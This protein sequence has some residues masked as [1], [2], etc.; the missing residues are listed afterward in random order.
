MKIPLKTN[1]ILLI[2]IFSIFSTHSGTDI[3]AGLSLVVGDFA[4]ATH[5]GISVSFTPIT[6]LNQYFGLGG[7]IDYS[8]ITFDTDSDLKTGNHLLDIGV[9]PRSLFL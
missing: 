7:H 9:V 5:P 6:K 8:W 4:K 2:L 1:K 3:C